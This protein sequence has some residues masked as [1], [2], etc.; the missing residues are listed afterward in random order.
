M[1]EGK[2]INL[3]IIESEDLSIY[4][5][6]SN[7]PKFIGEF[8]YS[9]QVSKTEI[10]KIY[11]ERS[12]DS[13]TFIIEKKDRT[14][15]GV[16]HFFQTCFGGYVSVTEIGYLIVPSEYGKG[17]AT[18]AVGII[19]DYFFLLRD[20]VRIQAIIDNRNIASIRVLEKNGFK[21]EGTIRKLAFIKGKWEDGVLY[22]LLRE[23]WGGPKILR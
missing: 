18:E 7:D 2:N 3:R 17:Y 10:E 4:A 23:E 13:G 11:S 1:L 22:S 9:R 5:E 6:W 14:R 12:P 8:F 20:I 16:V 15:I 21:K 19:S